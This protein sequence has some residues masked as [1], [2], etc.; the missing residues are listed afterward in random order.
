[1]SRAT[2]LLGG[3]RGSENR[4]RTIWALVILSVL[5]VGYTW[6]ILT[7]LSRTHT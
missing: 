2:L 4:R 5:V 3:G 6:F 1:M 7:H